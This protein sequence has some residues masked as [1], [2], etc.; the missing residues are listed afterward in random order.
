MGVVAHAPRGFEGRQPHQP[1]VVFDRGTV[2]TRDLN[3]MEMA[4][5][6]T[7][8]DIGPSPILPCLGDQLARFHLK[9]GFLPELA[10]QCLDGAFA[11]IE[12]T[13]GQ[14]IFKGWTQADLGHRDPPEHVKPDAIGAGSVR[15][16]GPGTAQPELGNVLQHDH[17]SVSMVLVH[18]S[19]FAP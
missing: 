3:D 15:V 16:V 5:G 19:G 18:S 2:V 1:M 9:A 14:V 12:P 13:A 11:V 4:Q 10:D 17:N 8:P 7:R 6:I